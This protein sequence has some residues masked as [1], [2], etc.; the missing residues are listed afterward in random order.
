MKIV[1]ATGLGGLW[2]LLWAWHIR[3][4]GLFDVVHHNANF[5]RPLLGRKP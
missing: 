1:G 5:Q 2:A 3:T 4:V